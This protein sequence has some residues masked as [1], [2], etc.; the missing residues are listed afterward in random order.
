MAHAAQ[1]IQSDASGALF[2]V[3]VDKDGTV[4]TTQLKGPDGK[5]LQGPKN[6]DA[7]TGMFVKA[8]TDTADLAARNGDTEGHDMAIQRLNML[9]SGTPL[10]DVMGLAPSDVPNPRALAALQTPEGQA[11]YAEFKAKW[12]KFAASME[13]G[14]QVPKAVV[15][16][17]SGTTSSSPNPFAD[18]ASTDATSTGTAGTPP[19][20]GANA[21]AAPVQ[22]VNRPPLVRG[23]LPPAA[24]GWQGRPEVTPPADVAPIVAPAPTVQPAP[25]PPTFAQSVKPAPFAA[26]APNVL[27]PV[28]QGLIAQ[29]FIQR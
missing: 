19:L 23:Q 22:Q 2:S 15:T 11:H 12:P 18:T 14:G 17:A 4:T 9:L 16:A 21:P 28:G 24:A 5:P 26:P 27:D 7:A 6:I 29:Q 13:N 10:K 20:P 1:S 25:A 8:L 3:G